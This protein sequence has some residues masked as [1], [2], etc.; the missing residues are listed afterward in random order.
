MDNFDIYVRDLEGVD[1]TIVCDDYCK[2]PTLVG[3]QEQLDSICDNC[4]YYKLLRLLDEVG[5]T[6]GI[7]YE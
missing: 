4:P 6:R 3:S 5:I 2:Y 1:L 7:D